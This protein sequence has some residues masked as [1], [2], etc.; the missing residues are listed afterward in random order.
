MKL[1]QLD[2]TYHIQR[3]VLRTVLLRRYSVRCETLGI[4]QL[5]LGSCSDRP[6]IGQRYLED[7]FSGVKRRSTVQAE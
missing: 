3:R 2:R 5:S 1:I 7:R 4:N 6:H